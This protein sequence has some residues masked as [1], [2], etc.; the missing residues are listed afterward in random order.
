MNNFEDNYPLGI[1][2]GSQIPKKR[3]VALAK[4]SDLDKWTPGKNI[5]TQCFNADWLYE[6]WFRS[7]EEATNP[8][9]QEPVDRAA[10]LY[11]KKLAE[12]NPEL[13][14][15]KEKIIIKLNLQECFLELSHQLKQL[16]S[17]L[18]MFML[19]LRNIWII[20]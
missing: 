9:N 16:L 10:V 14:K 11:F 13:T 2:S 17:I 6:T 20:G 5:N 3:L 19:I 7:Q 1:I 18:K 8:A 15:E 12:D 4:I